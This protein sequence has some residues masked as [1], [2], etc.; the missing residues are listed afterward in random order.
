MPQ[1]SF[2]LPFGGKKNQKLN[3]GY[4]RN[5]SAFITSKMVRNY[6]I[7]QSDIFFVSG[8]LSSFHIRLGNNVPF[9]LA[10]EMLKASILV[11][12]LSLASLYPVPKLH[13]SLSILMC[14]TV[15]L[16]LLFLN[17]LK[18]YTEEHRIQRSYRGNIKT[19]Q[20]KMYHMSKYILMCNVL[21][22]CNQWQKYNCK[23]SILHYFYKMLKVLTRLCLSLSL[24]FSRTQSI[25]WKSS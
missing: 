6:K 10:T 4:L 16:L 3:P 15:F 13:F 22:A 25:V 24:H 5:T 11:T 23:R 19:K 12:S 17:Y 9:A 20:R 7:L 1:F 8:T 18:P 21:V 2:W 14:L